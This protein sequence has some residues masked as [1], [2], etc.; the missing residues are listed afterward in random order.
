MRYEDLVAAVDVIVTKPGYGIYLGVHRERGPRML[1]TSRGN[2]TQVDVMVEQIPRFIRCEYIELEALLAGRWQASLERLQRKP[3]APERPE[4]N[5]AEIVAGMIV[6]RLSGAEPDGDKTLFHCH[7]Q[8][9]MDF[10][11][12]A[13]FRYA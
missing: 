4:T 6:E 1:Y 11:F 3:P 12:M 7:Q 8:L 13:L 5:G 9:H 2:F 10:G